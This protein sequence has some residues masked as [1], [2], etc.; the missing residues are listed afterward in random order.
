METFSFLVK[1]NNEH[2]NV[3]DVMYENYKAEA[4]GLKNYLI[5]S[6]S[7]KGV[8]YK[9]F[10]TRNFK[11][12]YF[13]R[14]DE[15][16]INNPPLEIYEYQL[17]FLLKRKDGSFVLLDGFR[18]LL[19]YN[20]PKCFINV[21]VY[22]ESTLSDHQIMK[23]LVYFN[24]LKF[25]GSIGAYYDRGFALGMRT[26]FDLNILIYHKV[27]DSYLSTTETVK[28]YWTDRP[29]SDIK[30]ERVKERM[31]NPF[32]VSDMKFIEALSKTGVMMN[33]VFGALV[34]KYRT[35]FPDKE[36][37][38]NFFNEKVKEN[39][40]ITDLH[41]KFNKSGDGNGARQQD[42]I[43]ELIKF[44]TNIFNEMFGLETRRT[45]TEILTE[46]KA[47][48]A[49]MKK[50]KGF[51][52]LSGNQKDYLIEMVF[53]KRM[54]ENIPIKVKGVVH[55]LKD[56]PYRHEDKRE[57]IIYLKPGVIEQEI[58]VIQ[59]PGKFGYS[60]Y[61]VRFE[62]EGILFSSGNTEYKPSFKKVEGTYPS[63]RTYDVDWFVDVTTEEI[64]WVN[65]HRNM[66]L[67]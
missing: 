8:D 36:F 33:D 13:G 18:R 3:I 41:E 17:F 39:K 26:I 43:N 49:V 59:K 5:E 28:K 51:I 21:R 1:L 31:L 2:D 66:E 65:E 53:R 10:N 14:G 64:D 58:R 23:L 40:F 7:E 16:V 35:D 50:E 25:Y 19:W 34:F 29:D 45:Y 37:D 4:I 6:L 38:L 56:D 42:N 22:D 48:V 24:H 30:I 61:E 12:D 11:E 54:K 55:P 15:N 52:K 60:K 57:K 47:A 27:F 67:W 9:N 46:T 62:Y 20:T 63:N 44:Y 32:F